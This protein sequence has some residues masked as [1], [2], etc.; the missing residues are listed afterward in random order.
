MTLTFNPLPATV[1]TYSHT[2]VQSQR[3]VG[4][5]D[6]VETDAVGNQSAEIFQTPNWLNG[7]YSMAN[8]DSVSDS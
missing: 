5:K 6:R 1:M 4:S 3:S 2:N 8:Q 7:H